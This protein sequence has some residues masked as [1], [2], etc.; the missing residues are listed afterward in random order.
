MDS[1]HIGHVRV[2]FW[3][4][5]VSSDVTELDES[6]EPAILTGESSLTGDAGCEP[7]L[8][9]IPFSSFILD[10]EDTRR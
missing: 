7:L 6:T 8:M 1:S 4:A 2:V 9:T 5:E 3:V 10:S